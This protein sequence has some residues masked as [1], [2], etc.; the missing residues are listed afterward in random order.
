VVKALTKKMKAKVRQGV[1]K[2]RRFA[3]GSLA[4]TYVAK[5]HARR[6]GACVRCGVCCRLLFR[7]PCLETLPDGVASCRIHAKRPRNCRIFPVSE[8]C[9]RDRD[10]LA[11]GIPCG[12]RFKTRSRSAG[13][14]RRKAV[15]R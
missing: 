6:E 13:S 9:I 11:P 14:Q 8:S 7:C 2:L 4:E 15:S 5:Q 1:G 12:Y 3:L 10:S